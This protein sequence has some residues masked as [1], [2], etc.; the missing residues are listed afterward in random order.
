MATTLY[1]GSHK[2]TLTLHEGLCLTDSDRVAEHYTQRVGKVFAVSLDLSSLTVEEC[3]GY[4]WDTDYAPADD[5]EFRAAAAARGVDVLEYQDADERGNQHTCYR[6]VSERALA[7]VQV[8][9]QC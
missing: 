4:D 9:E 7:A 2:G 6:L 3:D 8:T 1:H 5:S